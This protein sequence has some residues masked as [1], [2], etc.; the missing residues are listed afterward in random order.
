MEHLEQNKDLLPQNIEKLETVEEFESD[1]AK[2]RL[3]KSWHFYPNKI[4]ELG[5]P[6]VVVLE[7][8]FLHY[9]E[10]PKKTVKLAEDSIQYKDIVNELKKRE[11][12][13]YFVDIPFKKGSVGEKLGIERQ[14]EK[15]K[16]GSDFKEPKENPLLE[17][18]TKKLLTSTALLICLTKSLAVKMK[19]NEPIPRRE[20]LKSI[21][22]T[23]ATLFLASPLAN[24][25]YD[26]LENSLNSKLKAK[27]EYK[28]IMRELVVSFRN[29]VMAEKIEHLA[30]TTKD[31]Y[32]GEK[33][34]ITIF[35]GAAH[36]DSKDEMSL[37]NLLTLKQ[38]QA[39]GRVS[40]IH[41][42]LEK[43]NFSKFIIDPQEITR[44]SSVRFSKDKNDWE[45]ESNYDDYLL[46]GGR[47]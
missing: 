1:N 6:N 41:K 31:K 29:A 17:H 24:P 39:Y 10:D 18:S 4:R 25:L 23:S 28:R 34:N 16:C 43:P 30:K 15:L 7:T 45:V 40:I 22:K 13:I 20:I 33:P 19:S 47:G 46:G 5:N 44:I 11:V 2:Y 14:Q 32:K 42:F 3:V 36:A 9:K 37:N 8:G 12:P 35:M 38:E 27:K 26:F 21:I